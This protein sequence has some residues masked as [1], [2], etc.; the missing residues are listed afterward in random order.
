D[1]DE[2]PT[3]DEEEEEHLAPAD[4]SVVP[5]VDHVPSVGD[6]KAFE[7]DEY[8]PTPKPPQTRVPFSQTCLRKARKTVRLKPPMSASMEARIAQHAA[9]PIQPTSLA[10]DQTPLGHRAAMIRMR[11]DILEEGIPPRRRFVLT[12]PP[13]GRDIAESSAATAA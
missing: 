6:T 3:E 7:T 1:E 4:P 8:A 12:A 13:P 2:E 9:A 11:D 5:V 10:Y